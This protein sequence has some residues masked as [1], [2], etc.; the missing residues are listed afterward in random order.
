MIGV[1]GAGSAQF[2]LGLVKGVWLTASLRGSEVA[3]MDVDRERLEAVHRLAARYAAE[4]GANLRLEATTNRE[5]ALR[6]ADFVIN[7]AYAKG[8]Y[9]DRAMREV[10]ARHGYYYGG[11]WDTGSFYD[12]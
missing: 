12:F 1:V 8:H 3:F 6:D 5:V 2:S 9:H 11:Q 10:A 7:T 4:V